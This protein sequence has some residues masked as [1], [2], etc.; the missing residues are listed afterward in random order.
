MSALAIY[1]T[2]LTLPGLSQIVADLLA[3]AQGAGLSATAWTL[4]SPTRTWIEIVA[5]A[6]D[7]WGLVPSQAV[8]GFFL[9]LATD[10]GD[11]GD[12]TPDQTPRAGWLSA[13]GLSWYGV[14]R[15]GQTYAAPT[16][17]VKNTG[18]SP[19]TF[20]PYQ[21][22]AERNSVGSDGGS[23]TYRNTPD[24]TKYTNVD[25]SITI[26][27]GASV[28]LPFQADRIGS[29][30]SAIVNAITVIV[31][32]SYGPLSATA[33]TAATGLD[34][35]A[36]DAYRARCRVAAAGLAPGGPANA[37]VIAATTA[38]DGAALQRYDGS[39]PVGITT[40]YVSPSSATGVV[41]VYYS[42]P[43]GAVDATDVSSAT[44]NTWG[45]PLGVI[46]DP[47]GIVPDTVTLAPTASDANT[48]T[49]GGASATDQAIAVT[50]SARIRAKDVPGGATAGTYT[51]GGA[52]PANVAAL[53]TQAASA[54]G[55]WLP[56]LGPSAKDPDVSGNGVVYTRD[57]EET[58]KGAVT[59]LYNVSASTPSSSTTAVPLG[60][61]PIAGTISGTLVVV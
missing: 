33:S 55:V 42:G 32:Q 58:I 48:H 31:T 12:L 2:L 34:R 8:K 41:T 13:L 43:S 54:L 24:A 14:Q 56:S 16:V 10:P 38:K 20:K 7:A 6:L 50:W 17:T 9:D 49:S 40:V 5:R 23:V 53:F 61:V 18:T 22:T 29:D 3:I 37:Y 35:E 46:T 47:R 1:A 44:A 11:A 45:V 59:G 30:A 57:I 39:G 26:S 4:G 25:G 28:V 52:P 19:I 27:A 60:Y 51:S 36:A 15:G 21:I